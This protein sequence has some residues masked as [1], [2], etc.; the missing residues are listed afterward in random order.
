MEVIRSPRLN[1][2]V[3]PLGG[4]SIEFLAPIAE[5]YGIDIID[6]E[7]VNDTVGPTF[8]FMSLDWDGRVRMDCS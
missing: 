1:I 3:D 8:G 6:I 2:G 4:A 5:R 7:V